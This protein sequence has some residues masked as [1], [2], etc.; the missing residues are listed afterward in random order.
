MARSRYCR[1]CSGF[2]D[3]NEPW[4]EACSGH[5]GVR[6]EA[7]AYVISDNMAPIISMADGKPYDSKS[8]YRQELRARGCYEVG[9]DRMERSPTPLPPVRD[10]LRQTI[11]QLRS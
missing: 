8:R 10:A 6:A 7:A 5:F 11:S 4:P 2:H 1:V 3:L 9:N